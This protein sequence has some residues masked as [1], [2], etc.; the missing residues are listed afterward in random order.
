MIHRFHFSSQLKRMATIVSTEVDRKTE[1]YALI[2]GAP[3]KLFQFYDKS[4]VSQLNIRVN[5]QI[6]S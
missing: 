2:K 6:D 4:T 3:E 5:N 1:Y